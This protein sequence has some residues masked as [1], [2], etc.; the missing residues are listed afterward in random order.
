M[1]ASKTTKEF[2]NVEKAASLPK[3]MKKNDLE[4]EALNIISDVIGLKVSSIEELKEFT[5]IKEVKEMLKNL[6]TNKGVVESMPDHFLMEGV[7]VDQWTVIQEVGL[8]NKVIERNREIEARKLATDYAQ[9]LE[10]LHKK[11]DQ[12]LKKPLDPEIARI[13][14]AK[15]AQLKD[16]PIKVQAD[17][18]ANLIGKSTSEQ[19]LIRKKALETYQISLFRN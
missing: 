7:T 18:Q 19:K 11:F 4:T 17:L 15:K 2:E 9:K 10:I 12:Q 6:N 13:M 1:Q 5:T 16:A 8:E 3:E 14:Y